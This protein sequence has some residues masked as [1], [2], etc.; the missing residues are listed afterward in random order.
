[1]RFTPAF[2]ITTR[3]SALVFSN[4]LH[5]YAEDLPEGLI[6]NDCEILSIFDDF[7][8]QLSRLEIMIPSRQDLL[9]KADFEVERQW[10]LIV[11]NNLNGWREY[12]YRLA[13]Q[14]VKWT[15]YDFPVA[16]Q[17]TVPQNDMTHFV[18]VSMRRSME[19]LH[20]SIDSEYDRQDHGHR[21]ESL[22]SIMLH[23]LYEAVKYVLEQAII[24]AAGGSGTAQGYHAHLL[25]A[26]EIHLP[27][28]MQR[29]GEGHA[30][31]LS[32]QRFLTTLITD[33]VEIEIRHARIIAQI[34]GPDGLV[35]RQYKAVS[36]D[37]FEKYVQSEDGRDAQ[38][39]DDSD[40]QHEV[41]RDDEA[42]DEESSESGW[43]SDISEVV[44]E[45][46][47]LALSSSNIAALLA[48]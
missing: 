8:K 33:V 45:V 19:E 23:P 34:E 9:A 43:E 4:F 21:N 32:M 38:S 14:H 44:E 3:S 5:I 42:G 22:T 30:D 13:P 16:I 18:N 11:A 6:L 20:S 46:A 24:D 15:T 35:R 7:R 10:I 25:A 36:T 27:I 12:M 26:V 47:Q 41:Q 29:V 2:R 17:R 48:A 28:L 40:G 31:A 1:G 37:D 39:E